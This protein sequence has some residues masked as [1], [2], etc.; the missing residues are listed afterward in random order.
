MGTT[1]IWLRGVGV[2][3]YMLLVGFFS[4]WSMLG[5]IYYRAG[6]GRYWLLASV[7]SAFGAVLFLCYVA[8]AAEPPWW[9]RSIAMILTR[10]VAMGGAIAA[11]YLTAWVLTREWG[12]SEH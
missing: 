4:L 5:V 8:V 9:N 11:W 12:K 6:R 2:A 7:A 10:S 3:A 1:D